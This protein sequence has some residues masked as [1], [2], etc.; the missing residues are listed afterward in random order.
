MKSL[1]LV[2]F[3]F[4]T[5]PPNLF[6]AEVQPQNTNKENKRMDGV[7]WQ[8]LENRSPQGSLILYT[9]GFI[10]GY[11]YALSLLQEVVKTQN[12]DKLGLIEF[13]DML[14]YPKNY[15]NSQIKTLIDKFYADEKNQELPLFV[16]FTYA[17]QVLSG[18]PKEYS[19]SYIED[20][21]QIYSKE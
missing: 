11:D 17:R 5:I 1:L 19:I 7:F 2:L 8:I 9:S 12:Y 6:S 15:T 10:S 18:Y 14:K 21:R 3:I 16:A 13:I 20:M 4:F